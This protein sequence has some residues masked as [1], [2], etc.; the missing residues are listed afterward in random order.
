MK[1]IYLFALASVF[2][3]AA[4]AQIDV[5]FRV[6]MNGQVVNANGVHVA[7]DFQS[8]AG[9]PSDWQPFTAQLLDG[10]GDNIY[11]LTVNIPAGQYEFK[12]INGN[13]W[14]FEEGIPTISQKGGGNTNR[15]FAV[16]QWH[17]DNGGLVLPAIL[18]GGSASAGNVAVRLQS[19]LFFETPSEL[20]VHVAGDFSDPQWTPQ[21]STAFSAFN[22]TY[23]FIADVAPNATY[24]YKFL[25]GDFWGDDELVPGA[26]ATANNRTIVVGAED[27][28]ATAF[29]Y[30]AC[31]TCTDPVSV[32]FKVDMNGAG[33]INPAGAHIAG[34]MNGWTGEPMTDEGNGIYS[35]TFDLFP[36]AVNWKFQ[37]GPGGWEPDV[38][39]NQPCGNPDNNN[40]TFMVEASETPVVVGPFC[41]ATCDAACDVPDPASITFRVDMNAETVAPEGVFLISSFF[42]WQAEP[43]TMEDLD[44]DGVYEVTLAYSGPATVVYKFVNGDVSVTANEEFDG[45][46]EV[47]STCGLVDNNNGGWNRTHIRTGVDEVLNITPFGDCPTLSTTNVELGMVNIYPNPSNGATFVEIENPNGYNLRMSVIDIAGKTVRDNIIF[48]NARKEINTSN[49]APGIYFLNVTNERSERMV[50]KLMVQ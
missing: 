8:E 20:G 19:D 2:G 9:F 27:V 48:N 42:A 21:L 1:K 5:T 31:E 24:S 18:F 23:A 13:D 30:G 28:T 36:G 16:T 39:Q 11:E 49:F 37:N 38:F 40:R 47:P 10:D 41:F 15:V 43:Q 3:T 33:N 17:G 4:M 44:L 22:T 12:Y 32:T 25:N 29:C 7:G 45:A 35:I 34:E 6:D 46:L 14:P 26:C 50:Y